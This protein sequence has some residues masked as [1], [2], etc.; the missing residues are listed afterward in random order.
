MITL[1]E[2]QCFKILFQ[3]EHIHHGKEE[4]SGHVYS[5]KNKNLISCLSSETPEKD[6]QKIHDQRR[7]EL[8]AKW[9]KEAGYPKNVKF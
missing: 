9:N 4:K 6:F 7:L 3:K 8:P 2:F 5:K 1:S